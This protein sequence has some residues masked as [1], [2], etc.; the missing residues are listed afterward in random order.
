MATNLDPFVI[1]NLGIYGVIRESEVDSDLLPEQAVV[2]A[3]NVSFDRKGTMTVRPGLTILGS[4]MGSGSATFGLFSA[5]FN[6]TSAGTLLATGSDGPNNDVYVFTEATNAWTKSKL[7][8]TAGAKTR[9]TVFTN[10]VIAVNRSN[11]LAFWAAT[12]DTTWIASGNPINAHQL[13]VQGGLAANIVPEVIETFKSKVY[14]AGDSTNPDR[15]YYSSV[16]SSASNITWTPSTDFIDIQPS[17]GENITALKRYSLTLLIFKPNY[18]YRYHGIE[19]L[20]PDPLINVGTRSQE[21]VV[22]A[23]DGCYFHHDSGFY[24]YAGGMP[25]E[26]SRPISDIVDAIP[27]SSYANFS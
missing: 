24:K 25:Q 20:D 15:L 7:D 19:G 14:I 11:P 12:S 10:R 6:N 5:S 3:V 4:Q 9:F 23:K 18:I 26:I 22:V 2:E 27:K 17:D 21:S 1:K 8:D 16:I 13:T